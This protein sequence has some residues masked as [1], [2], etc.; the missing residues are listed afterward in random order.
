LNINVNYEAHYQVNDS[1]RVVSHPLLQL[2]GI[3]IHQ[4]I[5][6]IQGLQGRQSPGVVV[7]PSVTIL[8]VVSGVVV[9][10]VVVS[11]VVVFGVVVS[12][13]VVSGAPVIEY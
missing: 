9:F 1:L 4:I 10:V 5:Q 8:V 13:V 2:Q 11:G 6:G 3:H 7:V 12:G